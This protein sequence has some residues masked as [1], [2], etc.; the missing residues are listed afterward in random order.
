M[1]C[2]ARALQWGSRREVP[3]RLGDCHDDAVH[4]VFRPSFGRVLSVAIGAL[5]A[6]VF[7]ALAIQDM[8]T[9]WLAA[10][11]LALTAGACWAIFWR[12][13]VI[14]EESGVRLVNILR[15]IDL[16]WP[17]IQAVDTK[18][19]LTLITAYGNFNGWAAPAPGA[20]ETRR[21]SKQDTKHLPPST[22]REGT[23]RPGDLPTSTSGS[24]ALVI[25]HH[26]EQLRDAGYLDN[27]RLEHERV[28]VRW[29][30]RTIAVGVALT[31]LCVV[32]LLV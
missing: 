31:I 27:P 14:V 29:H 23:I 25:R 24:A 26:W 19:A 18:W 7:V 9:A 20:F 5:C 32:T 1:W 3:F 11:W 8:T 16:P 6:V 30:V 2:A 22:A 4:H 12:P 10:P 17:A 28:P 13:E 21:A 15:T